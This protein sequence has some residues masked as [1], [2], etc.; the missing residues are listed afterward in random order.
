M[1]R[2]TTDRVKESLFQILETSFGVDWRKRQ[3]VDLFA[4]SGTL[5]MEALSRGARSAI[6]V[7]RERQPAQAL[8]EN[9]NRC[10]V[11][12]RARLIRKDVFRV[13]KTGSLFRSGQKVDLSW[14][15]FADPPYG[16]GLSSR[17]LQMISETGGGL[18][19]DDMVVV[20]ESS[21]E[22]L[23]AAFHGAALGLE[24]KDRRVYGD[25]AIFFYAIGP[26]AK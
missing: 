22:D 12:S 23:A 15:V 10:E 19:E 2:P 24:L 25:T 4:G 3:V 7:E 8:K 16:R 6:F 11:A 17:L 1:V 13:L 21:K 20:E 14:L 5:G 18:G 26:S 9:L